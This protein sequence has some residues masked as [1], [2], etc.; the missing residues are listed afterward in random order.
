VNQNEVEILTPEHV[1]LR[2]QTAGLGRRSAAQLIDCMIIYGII[3]IMFIAAAIAGVFEEDVLSFAEGLVLAVIIL[4]SFLI[5]FGYGICF[6]YFWNGQTPGKR[7]LKLKV[8]QE[9][10]QPL[11]FLSAAIRNLLRLIDFLPGGYM[12]GCLFIFFH[13]RH[14]RIGD[15]VAGTIVIYQNPGASEKELKQKAM[16]HDEL[17][18]KVAPLDL[19]TLASMSFTIDDWQLLA[20]YIRKK[21]DLPEKEQE[22]I[23]KKIAQKL[24]PKAGIDP[25]ERTLK[26]CEQDLTALYLALRSE[27]EHI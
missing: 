13:P 26:E 17:S 19:D 9:Q 11:T 5:M 8:V 22:G 21:K 2:F 1:V 16:F 24:L 7:V 23:T 12:L 3:A 14:Q 15:L 10:G 27:W 4:I 25:Q 18:R 6:E 20:V